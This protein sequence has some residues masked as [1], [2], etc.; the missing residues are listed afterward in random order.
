LPTISWRQ[1]PDAIHLQGM[2]Q[3]VYP[4]RHIAKARESKQRAED[5]AEEQQGKEYPSCIMGL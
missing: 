5:D 2:I 4:G 3:L 1:H